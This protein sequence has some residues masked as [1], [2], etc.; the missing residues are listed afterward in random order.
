MSNNNWND[1]STLTL[2]ERLKQ[3]VNLSYELLCNKIVGKNI[4]IHNEAS[5]QMQLGVILKQ[6][7]QLY[8][9][10]EN[11]HFSIELETWQDISSTTKSNKGKARCDISLKL[12]NGEESKESA[13]ELK[14]FKYSPNDAVTD[15]RFSLLL[16]IENLEQYRK[17]KPGL[18]CYEIVY[19]D[20]KNYADPNN[21]SKIK[22]TPTISGNVE[23][24]AGRT[25]Q[26]QN[27]YSSIWDSFNERNHFLKIDLQ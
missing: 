14:Y 27:S 4:T 12:T 16:D 2:E 3:I 7:G 25:I 11:D 21:P 5:M 9:F 8:E 22:I 13:I 17:N 10:S 1:R 6:V 24:Y 19:T 26:L 20:N 15:N 23:P 18:L